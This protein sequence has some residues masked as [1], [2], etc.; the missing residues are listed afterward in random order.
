MIFSLVVFWCIP[1]ILSRAS[2][3]IRYSPLAS[4]G[5]GIPGTIISINIIL[6]AILVAIIITAIGL[7][8]I[9]AMV[10]EVGIFIISVGITLV[11]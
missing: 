6:A 3:K 8:L 2:N 4:L 5:S 1:S 7:R 9:F 10:W 11:T